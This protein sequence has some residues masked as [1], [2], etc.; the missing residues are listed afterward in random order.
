M[1]NK[2]MSTED[3]EIANK[4]GRPHKSGEDITRQTAQTS[5][6]KEV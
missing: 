3:K 5:K 4:I 1:Q 2:F 6:I